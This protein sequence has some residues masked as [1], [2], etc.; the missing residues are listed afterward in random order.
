MDCSLGMKKIPTS[1][2]TSSVSDYDPEEKEE[3]ITN[4]RAVALAGV[5]TFLSAVENTVV[6][7]AEWPYMHTVSL[8]IFP[9]G[10]KIFQIDPDATSAFF[11][12][13]SSVSK[14][15]HA[16]FAL[17]FSFWC[18]KTQT[19]RWPLIAGRILAFFAC[20]LYLCVEF[21]PEGR[22]YLMMTCYLFFGIASSRKSPFYS[23]KLDFPGSSA[24]L[25][26]YVVM[27]SSHAHRSKAYAAIVV[28]NMISIVIGPG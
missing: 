20:C 27:F 16:V 11:G 19:V 23:R 14:C 22:R 7:M 26:V 24:I 12:F 13:A 1:A 2:S 15:G 5:V 10:P 28:A 25:R 3:T 18:Y 9:I 6:G 4:W 21:V 17:V 8:L